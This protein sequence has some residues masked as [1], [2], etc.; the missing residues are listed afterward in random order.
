MV[1]TNPFLPVNT[2]AV[3]KL[4]QVKLR[5]GVNRMDDDRDQ[6]NAESRKK[7]FDLAA[8]QHISMHQSCSER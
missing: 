7:L 6:V 4:H 3:P 5:F 2:R 8:S 1:H